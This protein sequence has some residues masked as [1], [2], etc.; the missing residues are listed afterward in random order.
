M[1]SPSR[2]E[3]PPPP[4]RPASITPLTPFNTGE[5]PPPSPIS[6][7]HEDNSCLLQVPPPTYAPPR[8]N[9]PTPDGS[10]REPWR[11]TFT[12]LASPERHRTRRVYPEIEPFRGVSPCRQKQ[13]KASRDSLNAAIGLLIVVGVI[14]AFYFGL[15]SID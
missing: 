2:P 15:R 12:R 14:L 4:Y 7:Y 1:D 8:P 3:T 6:I 11:P 13:P 5:Q 10:S 9:V